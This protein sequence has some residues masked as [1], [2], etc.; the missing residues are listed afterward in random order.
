M[1]LQGFIRI[2][3]KNGELI[4]ISEP[5]DPRLEITEITDR[6]SK[7]YG[8]GKC[9]LFENTGT[10]FPVLINALGSAE[11]IRIAFGNR[12]PEEMALEIQSLL[13]QLTGPG[14]G[15]LSKIPL[16]SKASRWMPRKR[17]GKGTCQEI[18]ELNP[19]LNKLPVLTCWP[20]D[21][22]PFITLPLVHTKDP[23]TGVPNLGMYRMQVFDSKTTGMHWHMH[24]TGARHYREYK[25]AGQRMPVSV[26]LGG[27]P[28]YTYCATAPLPDGIDEYILAGFIRNKPVRLVKCLTNDLYVPEDCDF[29]IEG[30][31]DPVEDLVTEG[32]FGDHT[33][34]YSLED[35]YPL[36]HVT[37]ITS[38]RDPV[39]PATIVGIPPME[40]AWLEWATER[41]F[42]PLIRLSLV[43]ELS[44]FHMP[45]P[46]VAHNLV[47]ARINSSY[48][49]QGRKVLHTLWGAGQMMFTKFAV[50]LDDP[51]ELTDYVKVAKA[52]TQRVDPSVHT[53]ITSGP[54][55]ILDHSGALFAFGGK[56]GIDATGPVIAG[57][58]DPVCYQVNDFEISSFRSAHPE[59]TGM[60]LQWLSQ[61]ISLI[62]VGI[63]KGR[64]GQVRDLIDEIRLTDAFDNIRF[65]VFYD[66]QADLQNPWDLVWLAGAHVDAA[67]DIKIFAPTPH[68]RFGALFIDATV[69]LGTL[70]EFSRAW[71]N[72]VVMDLATI[73]VVD[74]RW[75]K[76]GIGPF[77]PSPSRKYSLLSRPGKARIEP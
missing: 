1:D 51:A 12:K 72:P 2:L 63:Q 73:N 44:A 40:D 20:H 64:A 32:P 47:L 39:Y 35:Q 34:F 5:V 58:G 31:V 69:K 19:D 10:Q 21:G 55:D 38:R 6:F 62:L 3:E 14:K 46:G 16:L 37:A 56:L 49:G 74:D 48:P 29:V 52:V 71:P 50:I 18:I 8:G 53:E 75:N 42:E 27:D 13:G 76:Y 43:P 25:K 70:D 22:G 15:A 67:R 57:S 61:G 41:L 7:T 60:N 9:L 23:E 65:W 28:V 36:F 59:I 66:A 24:K 33:G 45:T 30:Y 26:A 68:R 4:R 11:R 54:L 77:I 17:K